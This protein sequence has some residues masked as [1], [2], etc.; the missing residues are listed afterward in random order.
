MSTK[1]FITVTARTS[2]TMI[3][4]K[5]TAA[6]RNCLGKEKEAAHIYRKLDSKY[7]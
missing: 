1:E 5:E 6:L 2:L 7:K 4:K 3:V